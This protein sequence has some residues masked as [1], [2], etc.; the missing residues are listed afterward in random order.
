MTWVVV[1]LGLAA[2]VFL[3]ELGHF[4]VARLVGM[5]PRALFVGFGPAIVKV[6]RNG[7]EYGI[8]AI[9]LGGYTR[10]PG[11]HRPSASDFETLMSAAVA[12]DPALRGPVNVVG[13]ALEAE[14][15][16]GAR[17]ALPALNGALEQAR[18]S[19]SARR[20]AERAVRD[21]DEGSGADA[22]WRQPT[23]K[24]IA[25]IA[26]GPG[27]NVLVAFLLFFAVYATGAPSSTPST[28]VARVEA[29]SPAAAAG[30]R[31]GDRIVAVDG[32]PTRTFTRVSALLRASHGRA[33]AVTVEREGRQ[34]TLGPSRL[35]K[36]DGRW[37]WGF[38][39]AWRLVSH[40]VGES[41]RLAIGDC[42]Q[43]VT[44]TVA[45]VRGLVQ[46]RDGAQISGP[47]GI[48]RTSQQFLTVGVQWYLM[49]LGLIS[50]SLALY[51]M[52]PLLPLDGGHILVSLIEG[53]R[54]RAVP[55][56]VYERFSSFGMALILLVT[57]LAFANDLGAPAR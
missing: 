17:A 28:S 51:N 16:E 49:L 22:Y 25:A 12:E 53:L 1:I 40:P 31:A 23:W 39:P 6:E 20:S 4:S 11:M 32:R 52:L 57:V 19:R 9:P 37:V 10:I 26:A 36:R 29:N 56:R 3:H 41:A 42:W 24:R 14:D 46:S 33:I 47:V 44:G 43:V 50:M 55:Q 15:T 30:L 13:R 54:G 5:K 34:V 35:V 18:L 21:V 38:V 27:M 7:I 45:A 48:V 2:L 8:G